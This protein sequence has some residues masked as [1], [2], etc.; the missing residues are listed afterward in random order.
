MRPGGR[1]HTG[2]VRTRD[3]SRLTG[4][5]VARGVALLGM[6]AVHVLPQTEA[7]G[8]ATTV[9]LV[10]SGRSAALFA[11]LAGVGLAL[12][13]DRW[14]LRGR[15]ALALR[16]VG[17][18][19]VG[20][21]LGTLDSG[22]AVILAY[23]AVLFVLVLPFL[24]LR[25]RPLL[26]LA[27]TWA[28]VLPVVSFLVRDDLVAPTRDNPEWS[29]LGDAGPLASE[30]LV[31]GYYPALPWLAYLLLGLGVGRLALRSTRVAGRIA[32]AGAGIA[33]LAHGSSAV[34]LGP[35]GGAE[36]IGA[37]LGLPPGDQLDGLLDEGLFGNVPTGTAW[38]L[39]VDA[40]HTTTPLDLAATGGT[41][42][43]V[44]GLALLV[45]ARAALLLAPLAAI[46]SMP[47]TLYTTHV[48]VL[49]VVDDADP[50]T[51]Y[52]VQVA[53]GVVFAVLW[54]RH[55]G[56]GPLEAALAVLTRPVS[57]RSRT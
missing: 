53:V 4:V 24:D 22:V 38:W 28:L 57:G 10:A 31:T 50:E 18:G 45:T 16:A 37:T 13:A 15:L 3:R 27:G 34:L 2:R 9:G 46:G 36:R 49:S 43:L 11:V 17:V 29:S 5:D 48:A 7:D 1:S 40:P 44:L 26:V 42:L 23:Y 52:L 33:L 39:A 56:R 30:L 35:L 6:V 54:R 20:L 25:A 14:R 8:S 21:L 47:L 12:T 41:A 32:V 55:V 19:A 51:S